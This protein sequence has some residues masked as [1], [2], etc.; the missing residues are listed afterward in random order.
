MFANIQR[1]FH[2]QAQRRAEHSSHLRVSAPSRQ[3]SSRL[4]AALEALE[5]SFLDRVIVIALIVAVLVTGATAFAS[6]ASATLAVLDA[7]LSATQATRP[8]LPDDFGPSQPDDTGASGQTFAASPSLIATLAEILGPNGS[9][10]WN[11]LSPVTIRRPQAHVTIKPGTV[12]TYAITDSTA[13]LTFSPPRPIVEARVL[14]LRV[15]P[16]LTRLDLHAD[17]SGT[18]H[19]SSSGISLPAKRFTLNWED[20]APLAAACSCGCQQPDCTCSSLRD[21]ALARESSLGIV[22]PAAAQPRRSEGTP[23]PDTRPLVTLYTAD[24]DWCAPCL[25]ER[26]KLTPATLA[27]LPFQIRVVK[28]DGSPQTHRERAG[29]WTITGTPAYVWLDAQGACHVAGQ[30]EAVPRTP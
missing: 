28:T 1:L 9:L 23:P 6:P 12:V 18:A 20:A 10:T 29:Q 16:E 15:T 30:L 21:S 25:A 19:T 11:P 14:G 17:N 8:E 26:A 24:G 5:D 22:S 27:K 7:D 2:T 4:L 3:P 13:T